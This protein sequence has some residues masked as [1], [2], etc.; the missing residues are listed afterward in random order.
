MQLGPDAVLILLG[1][2]PSGGSEL[3]KTEVVSTRLTTELHGITPM[4]KH[5]AFYVEGRDRG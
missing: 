3:G 5:V 1:V 4:I 2:R